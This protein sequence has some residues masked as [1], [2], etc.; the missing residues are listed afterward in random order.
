MSGQNLVRAVIASLIVSIPMAFITLTIVYV[1][2]NFLDL[3][4]HS[5][6][7]TLLAEGFGWYFLAGILA[8]VLTLF[9][10][11]KNRSQAH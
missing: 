1:D 8:S 6:F 11:S 5:R 7:W 2:G 10:T 9:F 3:V 4:S